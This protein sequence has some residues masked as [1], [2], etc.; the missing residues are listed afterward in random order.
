MDRRGSECEAMGTGEDAE[1]VWL[2]DD[3][4]LG[5]A[6]VNPSLHV[7]DGGMIQSNL[8]QEH[9]VGTNALNPSGTS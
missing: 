7:R 9:S 2:R 1:L 8:E 6:C 3:S 4:G 5:R